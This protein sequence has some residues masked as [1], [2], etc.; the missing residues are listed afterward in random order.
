MPWRFKVKVNRLFPVCVKPATT[1]GATS[2]RFIADERF[3]PERQRVV[4]QADVLIIGGG[5]SGSLAA[6]MLG[7]SGVDVAVVDPHDVY[8]SDFRCEKLDGGQLK[9]LAATG[10]A[11]DVVP[12]TVAAGTLWVARFGHLL[13][14]KPGVQNGIMYDDLV[15][16]VRAAIPARV[17]RIRA[18]A[19]EI[20]SGPDRQ[21]V[22]LSNGETVSAR[23]AVLASG[24]NPGLVHQLGLK[25]IELS[26]CH[27]ITIGFDVRPVGRPSFDFPALTYYPER[28]KDKAAFLTLFPVPGAMRANYMVYRELADPWLLDLRRDPVA[29]L[30]GAMP[31][32]AKITGPFD[33]VGPLRIRPA[34]LY[35]TE[36]HLQPGIVLVG[37]AFSTSCPAAGT[38]TGKALT[39]VERLC[40]VHIPAWLA[41]PGM[42]VDKIAAFY[43]DPE[44]VACDAFSLALAWNLRSRSIDPGLRWRADRLLRFLARFGAGVTRRALRRAPPGGPVRQA[45]ETKHA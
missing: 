32:L 9:L 15:N 20:A 5:L 25:R 42:G 19:K 6:A 10:L 40:N 21:T 33:V 24:L 22:T 29:A 18:K 2:I 3:A 41:S 31:G 4:R 12:A 11:A 7:R 23:L 8:P 36:G 43:A 17:P 13:D 28:A 35:A 14:A 27:S 37:D 39:D 26:R 38:G 45:P 30:H 44:K 34:D 1:A 16:T